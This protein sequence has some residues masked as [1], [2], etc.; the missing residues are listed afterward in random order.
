MDL[1]KFMMEFKIW[2]YIVIKDIIKFMI[3]L[4]IL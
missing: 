3:R 2:Y 4:N 1:L